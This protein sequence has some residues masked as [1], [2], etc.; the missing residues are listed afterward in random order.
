MSVAKSARLDLRNTKILSVLADICAS[1]LGSCFGSQVRM[2]RP[3]RLRIAGATY[4]VMARGN[5]KGSIFHD[6]RDRRRFTQILEE[7]A[8]E[9]SVE[10]FADCQ[11]GN[12]FHGVIHTPHPNVSA[13]MQQLD[14]RFGQYY[15]RRYGFVGHVFQTPFKCV[16]VDHDIHLLTE[17][18]Y[19]LYNPVAAGLV[20][21]VED[22]KWSSYKATVGSVPPPKYLSLQWLDVLFPAETRGESQQQFRDF[23]HSDR[24]I[25]SYLDQN[26]PAAGSERFSQAIRSF[27][28]EKL[29]GAYVPRAYRALGRPSLGAL[30]ADDQSR[31]DRNQVI[32]RAHVVHGYKLSEIAVTLALHP[33][34]VSRIVCTLRRRGA[35]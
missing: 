14:G 2:P 28:G 4:H 22:W 20:H 25:H 12:H 35:R 27:I 1:G 32:W 33:A 18:A 6:S 15:N 10:V 9:F 5:R 24:P 8:D 23:I 29:H 11:M 31:L 19:V 3:P 7:V 13:F 21:R 16:I 26:V 30:F 17:I 34:S